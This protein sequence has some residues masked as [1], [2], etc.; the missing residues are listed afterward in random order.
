[1]GTVVDNRSIG[2][3]ARQVNVTVPDAE[4]T[5]NANR[6]AVA[7][8]IA[9]A[10][11]RLRQIQTQ[12]TTF[13]GQADYGASNATNLNDLLHKSQTIATAVKDLATDLIW[14]ARQLSEQYDATT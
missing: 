14:L 3:Q 1:M 12:A 2:G 13:A 6:V 8:N 5:A 4:I 10:L 9:G 7:D 11:A